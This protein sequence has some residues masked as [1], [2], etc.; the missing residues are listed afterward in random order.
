MNKKELIEEITADRIVHNDNMIF[1]S[2]A[3]AKR[4]LK[5]IEKILNDFIANKINVYLKPEYKHDINKILNKKKSCDLES[6]IK[7][8]LDKELK[9]EIEIEDHIAD[10][11]MFLIAGYVRNDF[12]H[13]IF[14]NSARIEADFIDNYNIDQAIESGKIKSGYDVLEIAFKEKIIDLLYAF[15]EKA[16]GTLRCNIKQYLFEMEAIATYEREN[17]ILK[18][19]W[20]N[21]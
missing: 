16:S 1:D 6:F 15:K 4:L 11:I 19:G 18:E 3:K 2:K 8:E 7:S 17:L 12:Y 13:K 9:K 5:V 10:E 20:D 14:S 21:E